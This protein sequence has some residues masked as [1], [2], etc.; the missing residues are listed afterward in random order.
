VD[1]LQAQLS[2]G[3]PSKAPNPMKSKTHRDKEKAT[4]Q[5]GGKDAK[6]SGQGRSN[7]KKREQKEQGARP[8]G[9]K[10]HKKQ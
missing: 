3:K 5:K 8:G 6:A 9:G 2:R 7:A 10:R 1:A 4:G